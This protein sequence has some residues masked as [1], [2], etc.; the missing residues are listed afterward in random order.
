M[1]R[2]GYTLTAYKRDVRCVCAQAGAA[3]CV[4]QRVSE[5]GSSLLPPS[6]RPHNQALVVSH[7]AISSKHCQASETC[8]RYI[9]RLVCVQYMA[10][11]VLNDDRSLFVQHFSM[12]GIRH[13]TARTIER[14]RCNRP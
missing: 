6:N 3:K 13:H 2:H 12:Q 4:L 7:D 10:W 1:I 11:I 5:T 9:L 14:E 8:S